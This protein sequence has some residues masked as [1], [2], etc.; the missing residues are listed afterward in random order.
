M[1]NPGKKETQVTGGVTSAGALAAIPWMAA[2][3]TTGP[4]GI[5]ILIASARIA[6]DAIRAHRKGQC[7]GIVVGTN[8]AS[9]NFGVST[10]DFRC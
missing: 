9:S 4:V 1:K 10:Y 5:P 3:G 7:L 8:P 2:L 6:F